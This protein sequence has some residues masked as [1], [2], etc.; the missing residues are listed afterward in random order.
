M[1]REFTRGQC[2]RIISLDEEELTQRYPDN[3]VQIVNEHKGETG[4][5]EWIGKNRTG[6]SYEQVSESV[7]CEVKLHRSKQTIRLPAG[8]L[9]PC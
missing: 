5:I 2:V 9:E 4:D 8:L 6:D 1:Q 7:F 3:I